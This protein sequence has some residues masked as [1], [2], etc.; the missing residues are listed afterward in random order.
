MWPT[1]TLKAERIRASSFLEDLEILEKPYTFAPPISP[2]L[3]RVK[4]QH[5]RGIIGSLTNTLSKI[6]LVVPILF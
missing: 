2:S 4:E 1:I 6:P 5:T 3:F